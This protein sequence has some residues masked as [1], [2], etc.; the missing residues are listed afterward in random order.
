[1]KRITTWFMTTLS[2][3]VLLFSYKTS[4][5]PAPAVASAAMS[6]SNSASG[7][8]GSSSGG[9]TATGPDTTGDSAG[10]SDSSGSS[11]SNSSSGSS[12]SG[13]SSGSS[14][15]SGT[16]TGE[17]VMTRWGAVQVQITVQGGKI[18]ASQ[19]VVYPTDNPRDVEINSYAVP[20]YNQEAV[21]AQSSQIDAISGATVTWDG[22]TQSLQSAIDQAGL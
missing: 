12:S 4:L 1:M 18:T 16:Y 11:S 15:A 22:Y 2:I 13:S 8:S 17:S 3:V 14:G 5:G 6:T 10:S 9:T 21:A 19:A 7:S 20:T